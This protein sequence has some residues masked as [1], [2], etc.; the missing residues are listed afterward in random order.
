MENWTSNFLLSKMNRQKTNLK[1][2]NPHAYYTHYTTWI[3]RFL[4]NAKLLKRYAIEDTT[5]LCTVESGN[6]VIFHS[7]GNIQVYSTLNYI[8]FR[9][10]PY[11]GSLRSSMLPTYDYWLLMKSIIEDVQSFII[12]VIRDCYMK[13]FITFF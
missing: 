11:Q 13:D 4:I 10:G 2:L 5:F 3:R 1:F 8:I 7:F 6:S 12:L 9:L